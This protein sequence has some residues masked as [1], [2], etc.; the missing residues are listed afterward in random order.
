VSIYHDVCDQRFADQDS[1]DAHT[2][3][4]VE[5]AGLPWPNYGGE[6]DWTRCKSSSEMLAEG[7]VR[8]VSASP[9]GG[10]APLVVWTLPS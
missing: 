6:G 2:Y 3:E 4:S 5:V 8:E 7:F 1:F 9:T 10:V